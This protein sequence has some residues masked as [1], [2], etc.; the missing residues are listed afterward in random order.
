MPERSNAA[1]DPTYAARERALFVDLCTLYG[2]AMYAPS[3]LA[4]FDEAGNGG[5][6]L[7]QS[8]TV[9]RPVESCRDLNAI[10]DEAYRSGA[11]R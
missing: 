2:A 11:S 5:L 7:R 3:E 6:L 10:A 8:P 4:D 9:W 1:P